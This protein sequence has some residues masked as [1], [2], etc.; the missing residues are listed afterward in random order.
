[1]IDLQKSKGDNTLMAPQESSISLKRREIAIREEMD[2]IC[3]DDEVLA[4][5]QKLETLDDALSENH[6]EWD[7]G[8][9][10]D[11]LSE[12]PEDDPI[13]RSDYFD[14]LESHCSSSTSVMPNCALSPSSTCGSFS[15]VRSPAPP[16]AA[17]SKNPL[18]CDDTWNVRLEELTAYKLKHG[19]CL[20]PKKSRS[21]PQLGIWVMNQRGKTAQPSI[22][23]AVFVI[24]YC[25][26]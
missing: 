24:V 12:N 22:L 19:N 25:V 4:K 10:D 8:H 13:K 16:T 5:R 18:I 2:D 3:Y 21:N 26:N 23:C 17:N 15:Q 11:C 6:S 9:D 7:A 14:N 20:V 1:V